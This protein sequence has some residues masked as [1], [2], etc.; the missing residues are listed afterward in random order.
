MGYVLVIGGAKVPRD[1]GIWKL[2]LWFRCVCSM[3]KD[4]IH[5]GLLQFK[6][7]KFVP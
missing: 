2:Q 7:L 1:L 6:K 5:C 3:I 4:T